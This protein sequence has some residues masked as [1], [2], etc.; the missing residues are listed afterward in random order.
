MKPVVIVAAGG[1]GREAAAV[2]ER[3][4]EWDLI[5]FLDDQPAL[6][7]T[8]ICGKPVLGSIASAA[9]RADVSL[10]VC[11]GKG[12]A[13]RAIV[14]RLRELGVTDNRYATVIAADVH[15]PESCSIGPGSLL[16]SGTVLTSDVTLGSHV[17]V[18]PGVVLTHDNGVGDFATL[19]AQVALGGKVS[20]GEAA[21]LGM[22]CLVR[23]GLSVG[24]ESVLGMGA[25]L[26]HD[27]PPGETWIGMPARNIS[28]SS[29]LQEKVS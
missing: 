15:I 8:E 23:E 16:L 25:V 20:V 3:S 14:A 6:A 26:L 18:M 19:C 29:T 24:T 7:G 13:R 22:G 28:D 17:V 2:I 1:L 4:N 21:Y 27:L 11:A 5:G 9:D 10:L 12:H